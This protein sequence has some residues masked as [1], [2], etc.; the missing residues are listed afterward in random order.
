MKTRSILFNRLIISS[1]LCLYL[2]FFLFLL[3]PFDSIN[4]NHPYK[5]VQLFGYGLISFF[6]YFITDTF[7]SAK[8]LKF[9][10]NFVVFFLLGSSLCFVYNALII[11]HKSIK[12]A[13]FFFWIITYA[14]PVFVTMLPIIY[15]SKKINFYEKFY[16][17]FFP[18]IK[19]TGDNKSEELIIDPKS[20]VYAQAMENYVT[21][22]YIENDS[23]QN[24]IFRNKLKNIEEQ[25]RGI[26]Q[27][28]H[29]SFLVNEQFI[30]KIIKEG[31]K[32]FLVLR[33]E[34]IKIPLSKTVS[35]NFSS[36]NL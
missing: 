9:N 12:I 16:Y 7:S 8:K 23:L 27:N 34:N 31:Q 14:L 22:Y 24:I 4:Y 21:V 30:S 25:S 13:G 18:K 2:F 26:L 20:L 6:S 36:Q 11:N 10:K 5:T 3:Q 33:I 15:F 19:L 1:I 28:C 17:T 29:R 35:E 32:Q